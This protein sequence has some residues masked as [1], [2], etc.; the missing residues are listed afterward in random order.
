MKVLNVRYT[1]QVH[2]VR[3]SHNNQKILMRLI[4]K[5]QKMAKVINVALVFFKEVVD[6][7]GSF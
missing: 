1:R 5:A 2:A 4:G 7:E 3:A 6:D